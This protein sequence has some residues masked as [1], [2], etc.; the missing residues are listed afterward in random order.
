MCN[1]LYCKTVTFCCSFVQMKQTVYQED[2]NSLS[3]WRTGEDHRDTLMLCGWRLSNRTWNPI[4]SPWMKQ[5]T[6]LRIVHSGD[7]CIRL[8]CY[9]LLMVHARNQWMYSTIFLSFIFSIFKFSSL[10]P[11]VVTSSINFMFLSTLWRNAK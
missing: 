9:T 10:T 5:L 7:Q 1:F 8:A 6:W 3:P 2:L 4:T 11:T